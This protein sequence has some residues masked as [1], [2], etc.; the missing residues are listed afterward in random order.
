MKKWQRET[1]SNMPKTSKRGGVGVSRKPRNPSFVK[2]SITTARKNK[3]ERERAAE[4]AAAMRAADDAIADAAVALAV[5]EA[6]A[7]LADI[8]GADEASHL[9]AVQP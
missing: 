9:K 8:V 3:A 4:V 1:V 2:C 6:N 5:A 7:K